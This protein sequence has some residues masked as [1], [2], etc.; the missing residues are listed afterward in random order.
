M[1]KVGIYKLGFVPFGESNTGNQWVV[2]ESEEEMR[3]LSSSGSSVSTDEDEM[4]FT[5]KMFKAIDQDASEL[6]EE[7]TVDENGP[8]YHISLAATVR[9]DEDV[10]LGER[11]SGRQMAVH[12]WTVDGRHLTI[13]TEADPATLVTKDAYDNLHTRE[14][15]M[16]VDYDT[17]HGLLRS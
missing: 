10:A 12:V 2:V 4:Q 8:F 6:S 5:G 15:S 16:T 17:Q 1:A 13:G 3:A 9:R 14:L 11:Y 7:L